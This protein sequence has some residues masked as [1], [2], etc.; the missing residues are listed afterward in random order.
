M[1]AAA[2]EALSFDTLT[3]LTYG[4]SNLPVCSQEKRCVCL[5]SA[6]FHT[7]TQSS[8]PAE[9]SSC[10]SLENATSFTQSVWPLSLRRVVIP[11]SD[12]SDQSE[13]TE[14][15]RLHERRVKQGISGSRKNSTK[16]F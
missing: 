12:W 4:C 13:S 3:D 8:S 16:G 9:N 14:A 2:T 15:L 11:A 6:T 7:R 1:Q 5:P 10:P